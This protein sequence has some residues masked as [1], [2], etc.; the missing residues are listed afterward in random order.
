[1]VIRQSGSSG[2]LGTGRVPATQL[3][4]YSATINWDGMRSALIG[5]TGFI[6]GNLVRQRAFDRVYNSKDISSIR[7]EKFDV[8]VCAGITALKWWANQNEAEDR[9]RIDAL[10]S[11][12][13]F[14]RTEKVILISTVDVYP[15]VTVVDETFDCRSRPNHAYGANRLHFE[16]N[17]RNLF[18]SVS[19]GRIGG[20][21]G[22]GLKK[23]VI[24]DLLN[25]NCLDLINPASTFQY[26]N[27]SRLWRDLVHVME[28]NIPLINLVSEPVVTSDIIDR[29][30]PG[31]Q[32]GINAAPEVHYDVR[33]LYSREFAGPPHYLVDARSI[34][35]EVAEF[36]TAERARVRD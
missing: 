15:S 18:P 7:G 36:C 35:A 2:V 23:N 34:V 1:M 4:S 31:K 30:F 6:G 33:T 13:S 12:L 20:V 8:V 10:L 24:Y 32:V 29:C 21:F 16:D 28:H 25:D 17:V 14:I 26:Y 9:T 11:D 27:V 22:A 5:Y 3:D 19:I